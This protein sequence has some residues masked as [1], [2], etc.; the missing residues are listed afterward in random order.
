MGVFV[1]AIIALDHV[2]NLEPTQLVQ[3]RQLV[4]KELQ[5]LMRVANSLACGHHRGAHALVEGLQTLITFAPP[6]F[7][8][9]K[10]DC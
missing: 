8:E 10:V 7:L 1:V 9:A 3:K 5:Q 4:A 2:R 6:D